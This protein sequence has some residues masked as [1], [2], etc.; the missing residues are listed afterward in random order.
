MKTKYSVG[1]LLI[2]GIIIVGYTLWNT[3]KTDISYEDNYD[4]VVVDTDNNNPFE[5]L[6]I[7]IPD[8]DMKV[9]VHNKKLAN[10]KMYYYSDFE[11]VGSG[12]SGSVILLD[13]YSKNISDDEIVVPIV[14]NYSGSGQFTYI[15]YFKGSDNYQNVNSVFVGDR[16]LLSGLDLDQNNPGNIIVSYKH[17]SIDQA[18]VDEPQIPAIMSLSVASGRLMF[19]KSISNGSFDEIVLDNLDPYQK[20]ESD[21]VVTGSITAGWIFE[22]NLPVNIEDEAGNVLTNIKANVVGE[23][24]VDG[25]VPFVT[26]LKLSEKKPGTLFLVIDSDNPSGLAIHAKE[27]KIPFLL[28]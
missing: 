15:A 9:S 21:Y 20:V 11:D 14:V 28:K 7:A 10:D 2:I 18:L 13:E 22:A 1:A 4:S 17:H 27:F 8:T 5:G 12:S 19:Q 26:T 3:T 23:W 6:S 24:M 25:A 16:I